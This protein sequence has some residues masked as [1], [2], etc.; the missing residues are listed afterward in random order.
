MRKR[1]RY[2]LIGRILIAF[3]IIIFTIVISIQLNNIYVALREIGTNI[4]IK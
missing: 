2:A 4:F 1:D 3:S